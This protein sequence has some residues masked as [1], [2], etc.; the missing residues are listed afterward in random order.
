LLLCFQG[1]FDY[2]S[3]DNQKLLYDYHR[4]FRKIDNIIKKEDGSL[5]DFWLREFRSWLL[6]IVSSR[7]LLICLIDKTFIMH[8]YDIHYRGLH[9]YCFAGSSMPV[10]PR[11]STSLVFCKQ[12]FHIFG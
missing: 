7:R 11:A 6:G 10:G 8:M 3:A 4:A 12:S 5:P 2:T 1:D 9:C